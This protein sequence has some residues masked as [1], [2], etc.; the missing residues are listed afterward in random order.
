MKQSETFLPDRMLPSNWP[1]KKKNKKKL[2]T[3]PGNL[4]VR[5]EL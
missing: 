4:C 3:G 5:V 2:T 1:W